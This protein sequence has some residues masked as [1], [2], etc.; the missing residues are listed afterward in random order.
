MAQ[1]ACKY[2]DKCKNQNKKTKLKDWAYSL[3]YKVSTWVPCYGTH[4]TWNILPT[5]GMTIW[6]YG[7]FPLL[8][9]KLLLFSLDEGYSGKKPSWDVFSVIRS[10]MS[11]EIAQDMK[12]STVFLFLI[13]ALIFTKMNF[14]KFTLWFAD[15][16]WIHLDN[17]SETLQS[18]GRAH[19]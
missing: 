2:S 12:I 16:H 5:K 18:G 7:K 8:Y 3:Y 1:P 15:W 17:S 6:K 4:R 11:H 13:L 14:K 9:I 19:F 10:F